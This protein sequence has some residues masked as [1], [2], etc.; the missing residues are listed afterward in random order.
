[1]SA[2]PAPKR[3]RFNGPQRIES[4]VV[5][6]AS[7]GTTSHCP[8][9]A[10]ADETPTAT[11]GGT[12]GRVNTSAPAMTTTTTTGERTLSSASASG[13]EAAS[14]ETHLAYVLAQYAARE[15]F[16]ESA[17]HTW[18]DKGSNPALW[19]L[20]PLPLA[21]RTSRTGALVLLLPVRLED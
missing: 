14:I 9:P 8:C 16:I 13:S 7:A 4:A 20:S 15:K 12:P 3:A 1:M 17:F 2:P 19:L 10:A 5:I 21:S 11:G 18:R 6:T